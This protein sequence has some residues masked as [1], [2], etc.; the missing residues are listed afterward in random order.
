[1]LGTVAAMVND[2]DATDPADSARVITN[3]LLGGARTI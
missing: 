3:L 2:V 1:M